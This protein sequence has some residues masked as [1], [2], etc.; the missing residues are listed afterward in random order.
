MWHRRKGSKGAS[1]TQILPA[2]SRPHAAML[3][4]RGPSRLGHP[5][6]CPSIRCRAT[7]HVAKK[8]AGHGRRSVCCFKGRVRLTAPQGRGSANARAASRWCFAEAKTPASFRVVVTRKLPPC[9]STVSPTRIRRNVVERTFRRNMQRGI[10]DSNHALRESSSS[11]S[12]HTFAH[13]APR[14]RHAS[15]RAKSE[16]GTSRL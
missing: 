6:R 5:P 4:C 11:S 12:T 16:S 1:Q 9:A 13:F 10:D 15:G 14:E 2:M 7:R 8:N 3:Q